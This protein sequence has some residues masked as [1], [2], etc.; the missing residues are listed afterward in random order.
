MNTLEVRGAVDGLATSLA[1]QRIT[2][3]EIILLQQVFNQFIMYEEKENL[4]GSIKKDVEFHE[5]I[6]KASRNERILQIS[7]SFREQINRF[8]IIYLKS[9]NYSKEIIDEHKHILEAIVARDKEKARMYAEI[10]VKNQS[11]GIINSLRKMEL[12]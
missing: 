12:K 3:E 7:N 1:A 4:H 9:H 10:H 8:R 5:I 2:E 6:Y 11:D